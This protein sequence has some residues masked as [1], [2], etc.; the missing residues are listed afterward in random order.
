MFQ[1]ATGRFYRTLEQHEHAGEGV[2]FSNL[3][4]FS[5]LQTPLGDLRQSDNRVG[6]CGY[7]FHYTNRM[8]KREG[9]VLIRG[10]DQEIIDDL[11]ALLTAFLPGYFDARE[12]NVAQMARAGNPRDESLPRNFLPSKLATYVGNA[13]Q[14]VPA[15]EEKL[16]RLVKLSRNDYTTIL[17]A[18]RNF[19]LSIQALNYNFQL[20]YSL[21]IFS[22][23]TLLRTGPQIQP[24]WAN[25]SPELTG[26]IDE[27][28]QGSAPE[29]LKKVQEALLVDATLRITPRMVQLVKSNLSD[30][31][32]ESEAAGIRHAVR[33]SEID[34][35]IRNAYHL[36]SKFAHELHPGEGHLGIPMLADGETFT[37]ENKPYPTY[38]GLARMTEHVV[39]R[40]VLSLPAL[41][42]EDFDWRSEFPG[43]IQMYPAPQ[44]WL[45]L[46]RRPFRDQGRS[47]FGGLLQYLVLDLIPGKGIMDLDE[48]MKEVEI[49]LPETKQ[50]W[51]PNAYLLYEGTLAPALRRPN[52]KTFA[53][54]WEKKAPLDLATLCG[55]TYFGSSWPWRAAD[56]ESVLMN[57]IA[58]RHFKDSVT[59]PRGFEAVLLA[60]LANTFLIE[61]DRGKFNFHAKAALHEIPGVL[62]AQA[63]VRNGWANGA[64]IMNGDLL[65]RIFPKRFQ[66]ESTGD[67]S[68]PPSTPK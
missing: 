13:T 9:Q 37:W 40:L 68:A 39:S 11:S 58:T 30:E 10:G 35:L 32:F 17:R 49:V 55:V 43:T 45:H 44:H 66:S 56:V 47:F 42:R 63:V 57:H 14:L 3:Q 34:S 31:F 62:D 52:F 64:P 46:V 7:V 29:T 54:D 8:E 33:Q 15:C 6:M 65:A 41:D 16:T 26:R 2:L 59:L 61:G 38:R 60:V 12:S 28:L 67:V 53:E 24:T 51:L 18:V 22:L 50:S 5:S 25:M 21:L 23:E 19:K 20:A 4:V 48:V 36:R 27:A 1:I